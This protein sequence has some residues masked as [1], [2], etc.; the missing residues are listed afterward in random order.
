MTSDASTPR[1]AL[2]TQ[3]VGALLRLTT[4]R[5]PEAGGGTMAVLAASA[6][7]ALVVMSAR[8][9][10][11]ALGAPIVD[12]VE[13]WLDELAGLADDDAEGFASLMDALRLAVDDPQRPVAVEE[14]VRRAC[15]VPLRVCE[16]GTRAVELAALLADGGRPALSGD[17]RTGMYLGLAAV[18]SAAEL[19]R[20][21]AG[22]TVPELVTRTVFLADQAR[23]AMRPPTSARC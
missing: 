22:T 12:E 9:A 1:P 23:S 21:N 3:P 16:I 5:D 13:P 17:A 7:A 15:A 8:F 14:G 10:D 6:A 4:E 11:D 2:F 20:L 19:V 18:E